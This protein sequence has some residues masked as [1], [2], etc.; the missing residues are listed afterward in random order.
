MEGKAA[1][2]AKVVDAERMAEML[3]HARV[4]GFMSLHGGMA[5]FLDG[6]C[7]EEVTAARSGENHAYFARKKEEE[8]WERVS[9]VLTR[10]FGRS[11]LGKA[12]MA[13]VIGVDTAALLRRLVSGEA[14]ENLNTSLVLDELTVLH[15][16]MLHATSVPGAPSADEANAVEAVMATARGTLLVQSLGPFDSSFQAKNL[17]REA[18]R[19]LSDLHRLPPALMSTIRLA[20]GLGRKDQTTRHI[21]GQQAREE[22]KMHSAQYTVEVLKLAVRKLVN[23]LMLDEDW[24]LRMDALEKHL[25]AE[26]LERK[27]LCA[28]RSRKGRKEGSAKGSSSKPPHKELQKE[29]HQSR[30]VPGRTSMSAIARPVARGAESRENFFASENGKSTDRCRAGAF[31]QIECEMTEHISAEHEIIRDVKNTRQQSHLKTEKR[32]VV[33]ESS[34]SK[35]KTK[36]GQ[37]KRGCA[38]A[39]LQQREVTEVRLKARRREKERGIKENEAWG[40]MPSVI[41]LEK[42][43]KESGDSRAKRSRSRSVKDKEDGEGMKEGVQD[44]RQRRVVLQASGKRTISKKHRKTVCSALQSFEDD[45]IVHKGHLTQKQRRKARLSLLMNPWSASAELNALEQSTAF[46]RRRARSCCKDRK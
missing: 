10:S 4:F 1:K 36:M 13:H 22:M 26:C 5:S 17:F 9:R 11:N 33:L 37:K 20:R 32:L 25:H 16:C 3:C 45:K 42:R 18:K 41:R 40:K 14:L 21:L 30:S 23:A 39:E 44:E 43:N 2:T 27:K 19:V 34:K 29:R 15:R 28:A 46:P 8:Q 24:H 38:E 6:Q 12:F 31:A 35:R 7:A